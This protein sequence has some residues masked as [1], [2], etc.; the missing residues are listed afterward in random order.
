M[1]IET[2]IHAFNL[3]QNKMVIYLIWLIIKSKMLYSF[4]DGNKIEKVG[5]K[6]TPCQS[7]SS[8]RMYDCVQ[9]RVP[10]LQYSIVVSIILKLDTFSLFNK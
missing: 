1:L 8:F 6:D 10:L 2:L 9:I 7:V 3:E 5:K 4:E